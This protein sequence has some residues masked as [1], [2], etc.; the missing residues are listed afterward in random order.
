MPE[1]FDP[2]RRA[3]QGHSLYSHW[4]QHGSIGYLLVIH[5]NHGPVLYR[6]P[7]KR[8][9]RSEIVNSPHPCI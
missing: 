3:L 2:S 9:F 5:I 1:N 4:N 7:D 8:Q 6:F